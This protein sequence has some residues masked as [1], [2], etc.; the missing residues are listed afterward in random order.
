MARPNG[1]EGNGFRYGGEFLGNGNPQIVLCGWD[2]GD[3]NVIGARR[4]LTDFQSRLKLLPPSSPVV[5]YL[6]LLN[7]SNDGVSR[8]GVRK[9]IDHFGLT[10]LEMDRAIHSVRGASPQPDEVVATLEEYGALSD[11]DV[12]TVSAKDNRLD[13]NA[14]QYLLYRGIDRLRLQRPFQV[15]LEMHAP[16]KLRKLEKHAQESDRLQA[17]ALEE[18]VNGNLK[19]AILFMRKS[20][21]RL[22]RGDVRGR[23]G[24]MITQLETIVRRIN[25]Q[26]ENALLYALFGSGHIDGIYAGISRT[27]GY[28]STIDVTL[29][30]RHNLTQLEW[31]TMR[32][33]EDITD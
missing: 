33:P 18:V 5:L 6:E 3:F 20:D 16:K 28:M 11:E 21:H 30:S 10:A 9:V 31:D 29:T 25:D 4:I 14:S 22:L 26:G 7:I 13:L 1:L 2:H 32:K 24:E 19:N 23:E 15:E 12:L 8:R 17:F 27:V